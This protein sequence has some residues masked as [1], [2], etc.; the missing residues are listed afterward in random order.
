M[1]PEFDVW[2]VTLAMTVMTL[3][4]GVLY[5]AAPL[6]LFGCTRSEKNAGMAMTLVWLFLV[7][8]GAVTLFLVAA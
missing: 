7:L 1:T 3:T 2:R 5:I 4:G 8:A 6:W